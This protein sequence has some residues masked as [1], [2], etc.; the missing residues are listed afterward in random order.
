MHQTNSLGYRL[1]KKI[2][3]YA[4]KLYW[5]ILLSHN[6]QRKKKQEIKRRYKIF[7]IAMFKFLEAIQ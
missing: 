6:F 7:I 1:L 4:M 2:K 5:S 3:T